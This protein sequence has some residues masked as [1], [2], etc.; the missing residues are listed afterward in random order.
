MRLMIAQSDFNFRQ[1][2]MVG[3]IGF[4][5]LFTSRSFNTLIRASYSGLRTYVVFNP[6]KKCCFIGFEQILGDRVLLFVLPPVFN[7]VLVMENVFEITHLSVAAAEICACQT[8][9]VNRQTVPDNG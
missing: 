6:E 1:Q 9:A 7:K 3:P 5:N 2:K 8:K 4:D